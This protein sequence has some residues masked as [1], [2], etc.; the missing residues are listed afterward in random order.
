MWR[1]VVCD[2]EPQV[3]FTISRMVDAHWKEKHQTVGLFSAEALGRYLL[4]EKPG[5]ADI[6][7]MDIKL[8]DENG[9]QFSQQILDRW[10]RIRVIF[11][12]G[13][14]EYCE[15]IFRGRPTAFLVKPVKEDK[16]LFALDKAVQELTRNQEQYLAVRDRM[17]SSVRIPIPSIVYAESEG[18]LVRIQTE[19]QTVE[20]YL[21]LSE[22]EQQLSGQFVRCHQ[23]YLVNLQYV[24][25]LERGA[26]YLAD[27]KKIPI[28]HSRLQETR[29]QLARF[30][31]RQL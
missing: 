17:R 28:S 1:V 30:A 11:M 8:G 7:L 25:R 15:E 2:D 12:T 14:I 10:P 19:D 26:L 6:L 5:E 18:R 23:S 16:L 27:G 22:L 21:R 3:M 29:E 9:I 13:H 31:G 20:S 24:Q 4:T